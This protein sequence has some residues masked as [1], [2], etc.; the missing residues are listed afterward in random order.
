MTLAEPSYRTVVL[1]GPAEGGLV[2]VCCWHAGEAGA[3]SG[4]LS[5]CH[6]GQD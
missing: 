4:G 3:G 5:P 6:G 2:G 1:G